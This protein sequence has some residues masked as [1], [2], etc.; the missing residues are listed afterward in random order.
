[1]YKDD[2]VA[3]VAEQKTNLGNDIFDEKPEEKNCAKFKIAAL[4]E[5]YF[6]DCQVWNVAKLDLT[7]F[8]VFFLVVFQEWFWSLNVFMACKPYH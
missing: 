2:D 7:S 6:R 1:M 3:T 5:N 4:I 8:L